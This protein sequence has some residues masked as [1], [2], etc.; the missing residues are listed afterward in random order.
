MLEPHP[1]TVHCG[2]AWCHCGG[3]PAQSRRIPAHPPNDEGPLTCTYALTR[4]TRTLPGHTGSTTRRTGCT[5]RQP[6]TPSATS[7]TEHNPSERG[8]T[9]ASVRPK[10]P[11][12]QHGTGRSDP[13]FERRACWRGDARCRAA[14]HGRPPGPGRIRAGR[15]RSHRCAARLPTAQLKSADR[16]PAVLALACFRRC[17]APPVRR[18]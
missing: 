2:R 4:Y 14:H 6:S 11:P 5:P 13:D 10:N 15:R 17:R 8:S 7:G 16:L 18:S 1:M 3:Q 9:P 12:D